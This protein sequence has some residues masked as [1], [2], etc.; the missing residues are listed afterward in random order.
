MA[1]KK[2]SKKVSRKKIAKKSVVKK[3][4]KRSSS[5]AKNTQS[6]QAHKNAGSDVGAR[7]SIG[8]QRHAP[9]VLL[10]FGV[11]LVIA[12]VFY[13]LT[14]HEDSVLED[15]VLVSFAGSVITQEQVEIQ[16]Q[17]LPEQTRAMV[18]RE[19]VLEQ[20]INEELVIMHARNQGESVSVD[21]LEE[22]I[23]AL[24]RQTSASREELE[25]NVE[26][27]LGLSLG[28]LVERSILFNRG[29][30][31]IIQDVASPS[32]EEARAFYD[33]NSDLFEQ[34]AQVRARHIL[35]EEEALADELLARVNEGEDFCAL[36]EEYSQD[37]G[38][39]SNCGEYTFGRGVMVAPFEELSFSLEVGNTGIAPTSFGFH[40]IE[41]L[42][43]IDSGSVSFNDVRGDIIRE[44]LRERQETAFR[45]FLEDMREQA[46]I[47]YA[48]FE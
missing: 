37:P 41:K 3:T 4:S 11:I 44:L 16:Y 25:S 43:D 28:E 45:L 26:A 13:L 6:E 42:E 23:S 34:G 2:S 24:L 20:L 47:Q 27:S 18:S 9:L 1:K 38:S 29:S 19:D 46:N 17:A 36:V 5:V 8:W 10:F 39:V 33:D 12:G 22:E 15:G 48:S 40:I 31:L 35:V 21:E 7:K 14:T 30:E 32:E